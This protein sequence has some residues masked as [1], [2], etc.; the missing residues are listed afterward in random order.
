VLGGL[1]T[2]AARAALLAAVTHPHPKVRRA[3]ADALGT[4]RDADVA[5]ALLALR[6]DPSYFVVASAL[7]ALGKTR[8]ARAFDALA[9]ALGERS[10]NETIAG[11]AARGLPEL[12]DARALEPLVAATRRERPEPLR[13]AAVGALARLG[14]LVDGVRTAAADALERALE[15]PSYLVRLSTYAACET[16]ADARLLPV[17]DRNAT[18]ELDGRLRRDATEA[19]IRIRAAAKTPVEVV[20]L[21]EELDRLRDDVNRLRDRNDVHA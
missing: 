15:D 3:V 6:D 5:S 2:D 10:W 9:A 4:Y 11:G 12:A 14:T 19:A 1:R 7:T 20:R 18:A 16:L 17:L 8:D 13:R 21:R